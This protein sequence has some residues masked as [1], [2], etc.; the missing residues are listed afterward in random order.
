MSG[1]PPRRFLLM[2]E[3]VIPRYSDSIGVASDLAG[4]LNPF[5]S[6]LSSGASANLFDHPI[7]NLFA[8]MTDES[9]ERTARVVIGNGPCAFQSEASFGMSAVL[10]PAG[11]YCVNSAFA[12]NRAFLCLAVIPLIFSVQ[13]FA[14]GMVWTALGQQ[15]AQ[16]V[17]IAS[18]VFLTFALAF[19]PF[20][21]PLCGFLL[22]P[23]GGTKWTLGC[24]TVLGLIG[25]L[26]LFLPL[27]LNPDFLETRPM[28]HSLYYDMRK[29]PVFQWMPLVWWEILYVAVVAAIPMMSRTSGFFLFGVALVLS[30]A[31][32]HIFY[33][34]ASASVWC[35]FA[36]M[37]SLYLCFA[38]RGM[39][40]L[41]VVGVARAV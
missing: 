5:L 34:Y 9:S 22:T 23:D 19:W 26:A 32:S 12:K 10:L 21:I 39:P 37:L 29:S 7:H 35:F 17:R 4:W 3:L 8:R 1:L 16:F 6:P 33:W 2:V 27:A 41:K 25:G 24:V 36:A 40:L 13:Q 30:A 31:V 15:N 11:V 20:W 18:L 28:H 14:E 38:F